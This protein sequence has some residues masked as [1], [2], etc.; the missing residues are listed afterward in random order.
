MNDSCA[1]PA[2]GHPITTQRADREHT[3]VH[4][5]VLKDGHAVQGAYV[6]MLDTGGEFVA[7]LQTD[8]H[9]NFRFFPKPG[10]W[11]ISVVSAHGQ[12]R[13][14]VDAA[15]GKQTYAHITL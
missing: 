1:A 15:A 6:R 3:I 8:N 14:D 10:T 4:G 9:G 11:T 12:G 13:A 7:E 5:R 2:G